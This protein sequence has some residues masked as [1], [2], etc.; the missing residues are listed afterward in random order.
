MRQ[1]SVGRVKEVAI[2]WIPDYSIANHTPQGK[3]RVTCVGSL[4]PA[5]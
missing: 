3:Y 4:P 1:G 2:L 5:L